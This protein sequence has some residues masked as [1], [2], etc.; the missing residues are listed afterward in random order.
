MVKKARST[1]RREEALSRESIIDAS[2]EL[3]DGS[4]EGGLTFRTL[5]ERL[6]TGPGAIYWHIA[7][8][9]D[10]LTAA[11]DAVVARTMEARV[12]DARP[13][14]AIRALALGMFD[15]ID[16]HPWVGSALTRAPGQLPMV[17][18]L[19]GIGQQVRALGVPDEEQWATVSALLNYILGVGG[20]NA[21]NGQ[22]AQ[23]QGTDRSDFLEAVAT[24]W[25]RLDPDEYPFARSVAGQLRAH[26]DR[27]D[28]LAGI[29]LILRGIGSPRRR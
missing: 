6:A 10:L 14:A 17:R 3:L 7:S 15:A 25:S 19:E 29:D 20:Q 24:E 23:T 1:Q 21:A 5:S 4:G 18:I 27:M 13:K 12:V 28:F 2:I 8:K 16:A 22:L 9:S 26:D 11:C